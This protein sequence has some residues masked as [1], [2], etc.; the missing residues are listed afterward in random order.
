[1]IPWEHLIAFSA[2]YCRPVQEWAR[3]EG[4]L[5]GSLRN[6]LIGCWAVLPG[7]GGYAQLRHIGRGTMPGDADQGEPYKH[8]RDR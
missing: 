3:G 8:H 1:M 5:Q 6:A 4:D 2:L 7:R